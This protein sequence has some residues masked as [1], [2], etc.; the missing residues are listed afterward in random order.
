MKILIVGG[1]G[2]IGGAITKASVEANHEV[3]V[4]SRREPFDKWKNLSANYLQ[5]DWKDDAFAEKVV[6]DYFDV[7]VDT[8]IFNEKQIAR[9]LRIVNNHCKQFIYISTDSVYAHPNENLSED[10]EISLGDIK[11]E[12]GINKRRAELY[13]LSHS[14]E[15]SFNWSVIRPTLTFGDTRIPVGFTSK[16]GTYTL[17]DRIV[18]QKP[19]LRFDDNESRHSLCHVSIFGK[20]AV[21]LFLN[22]NAYRNFYHISD[23][24]SYTYNEIF[25]AIESIVGKKGIFVFVEAKVLKRYRPSIYKEMIY[26]KNPEFTLDN[27]NI[28]AI[29]PEMSFHVNL[30]DIMQ[31]TLNNLRDHREEVGDDS[32]YN[33]LTDLILI[34]SRSKLRNQDILRLVSEY[35]EGLPEDY[36]RKIERYDANTRKKNTIRYIKKTLSPVK[37]LIIK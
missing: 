3:T 15:Y 6:S 18:N 2:L 21:N 29:C 7:I 27:T 22:K 1:M 33:M 37:H 5:G 4:L 31:E 24:Y 8:Q 19:I 30:Q 9:S 12:Y 10:K 25:D 17:V 11:W 32:D 23:D 14:D 26:D 35:L 16:R 34:K 13:L 36:K 28:K 20:A